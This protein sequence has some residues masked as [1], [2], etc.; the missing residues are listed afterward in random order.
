VKQACYLEVMPSPIDLFESIAIAAT[1]RREDQSALGSRDARTQ[2]FLALVDDGFDPNQ[3]NESGISPLGIIGLLTRGSIKREEMF[4]LAKAILNLGG[5]PL[6]SDKALGTSIN[7]AHSSP[8]LN[9]IVTQL[10]QREK[11]GRGLRDKHGGTVLH[12]LAERHLELIADYA[13]EDHYSLPDE[14]YFHPELYLTLNDHGDSL[15]HTLW[16]TPDH[17]DAGWTNLDPLQRRRWSTTAA[18]LEAGLDVLSVNHE[19]IMVAE[20][21]EAA[22]KQGTALPEDDTWVRIET[23][24]AAHRLNTTTPSIQSQRSGPRL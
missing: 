23:A 1:E 6:Q 5:N 4:D 19:G 9:T 7:H 11:E 2:A 13:E 10:A 24:L 20:L 8:L 21:I 3:T 14:R 15:L 22:V 17:Y 12:Y 16:R 18:S